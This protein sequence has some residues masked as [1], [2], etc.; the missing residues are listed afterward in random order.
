MNMKFM[1]TYIRLLKMVA[2]LALAV[3]PAQAATA[4]VTAGPANVTLNYT[5]AATFTMALDQSTLTF[6]PTGITPV[7][8]AT[9][10]WN[11]AAYA[12]VEMAIQ[13]TSTTFINNISANVNGTSYVCN[14]SAVTF[15]GAGTNLCYNGGGV[16]NNSGLNLSYRHN[17]ASDNQSSVI[18]PVFFTTNVSGIAAGSY[19]ANAKFNAAIY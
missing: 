14:S 16:D 18:V 3:V 17:A 9:L 1:K 15:G 8:N 19:T 5:Q 11:V 13:I 10:T 4:Q 12:D 2:V 6:S 7:V